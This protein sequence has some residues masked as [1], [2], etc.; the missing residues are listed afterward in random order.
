[1]FLTEFVKGPGSGLGYTNVQIKDLMIAKESDAGILAAVNILKINERLEN[2]FQETELN[3][4]FKIHLFS[5]KG[6]PD[7][8]IDIKDLFTDWMQVT[9]EE[10]IT[11]CNH[12]SLYTEDT[13]WNEDLIWST[14]PS[15]NVG[16]LQKVQARLDA[17][18]PNK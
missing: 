4:I 2:H 10:I 11:S 14:K 7:D 8:V 17:H 9:P 15:S 5:P 18:H 6:A 16:L 3:D 13:T 12:F 1:M